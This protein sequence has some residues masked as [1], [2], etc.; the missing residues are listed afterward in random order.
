LPKQLLIVEAGDLSRFVMAHGCEKVGVVEVKILG[1]VMTEDGCMEGDVTFRVD[2]VE[3]R[4]FDVLL[5]FLDH[6]LDIILEK[7]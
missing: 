2:S 3:G 5:A 1:F 6:L 7:K 4:C